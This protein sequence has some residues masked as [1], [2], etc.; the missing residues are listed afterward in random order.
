MD[1][2][3]ANLRGR[4]HAATAQALLD[5]AEKA[6]LKYGYDKATMQ[7][8][9]TETGCAPGTFYLYFKS[10]QDI[11]DA[12]INRYMKTLF[13]KTR[14]A[15]D[16]SENPLEKM[17]LGI[18]ACFQFAREN[19]LFFQVALTSLPMRNRALRAKLMEMGHTEHADMKRHSIEQL[20]L[21]QQMGL[22]RKDIPA[23][24]LDEFL[25]AVIFSFIEQFA[26]DDPIQ[27]V[28]DK[29]KALWGLVTGGI[30]HEA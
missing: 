12:I 2:Q 15:M 3:P 13:E 24:T 20:R 7:Q 22:V 27:S 8:I 16:G 28:E 5:A 23:E 1:P 6:M 14:A 9:A 29:V 17:R 26:M 30:V 25:D 4:L 18:W 21:A 11:F 19:K 10:K